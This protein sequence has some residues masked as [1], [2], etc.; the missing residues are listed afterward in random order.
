M[1][2]LRI[3]LVLLLAAIPWS[4]SR[5]LATP[6]AIDFHT[7]SSGGQS[8]QN[9]CFRLSGTVGQAA[10]GYSSGLTLSVVAGFWAAAPTMGLD[11]IYFNG[12]EAC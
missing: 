4:G 3:V 8:L 9:S 11:E 2:F 1:F 10:P 5:A 7:I 6:P 12:F